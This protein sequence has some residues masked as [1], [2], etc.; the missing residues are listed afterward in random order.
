M[1][2]Y[3]SRPAVDAIIGLSP[4]ISVDKHSWNHSPR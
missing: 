4:S 3:E 2:T 1:V